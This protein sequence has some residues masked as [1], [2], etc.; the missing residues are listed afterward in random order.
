MV[1]FCYSFKR[2]TPLSPLSSASLSR[3]LFDSATLCFSL[4]LSAINQKPPSSGFDRSKTNSSQAPTASRVAPSRFPPSSLVSSRPLPSCTA[5]G[6]FAHSCPLS[7]SLTVEDGCPLNS[8]P[9]QPCQSACLSKD[10]DNFLMHVAFC[11]SPL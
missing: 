3:P 2:Q 5:L 4:L 10:C 9:A 7:A 6:A 1:S 11:V 8:H